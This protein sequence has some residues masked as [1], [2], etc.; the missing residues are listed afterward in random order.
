[1]PAAI[2]NLL[3]FV[4][5]LGG[6]IFIHELGHL[7]AALLGGVKV[8]EIGWGLPPRL[9]RIT[10]IRGT[11]VTLNWIPL[12]GF[13]RLKGEFDAGAPDSLL[14]RPPLIRLAIF[15]AGPLS[16]LLIGY[17]LLTLTFMVGWPDRVRILDVNDPSPAYS[18]GLRAGDIVLSANQARVTENTHLRDAIYASLG[19][20]MTLEVLRG[21]VTFTASFAPRQTWPEGQGPAGFT[22]SMEVVQYP[23]SSALRNAAKRMLLQ[24]QEFAF[25]PAR[26]LQGQ[27]QPDQVRFASPLGLKQISDQV[28]ENALFWEASF[29]LLNWAAIL[30]IALG[31]TNLLPLPALDGG[32]ILFVLVEILRGKAISVK[33]EKIVH[34]TGML[35]LFGLMFALLIRDIIEPIF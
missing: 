1:M 24:I 13:V 7:I 15:L 29:P 5:T 30:S 18:A 35:A 20:P 21:E 32:R 8:Q 27:I 12:G 16:N 19:E 10:S 23:L 4:T 2:R 33:L 28:V 34:A 26:L 17:L 25:L 31:I 14:S 3:I 6:L 9:R 11:E 22:S